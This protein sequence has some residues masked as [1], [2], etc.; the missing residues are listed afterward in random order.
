LALVGQAMLVAAGGLVLI[1]IAISLPRV[2]RVRR[3][4]S[5]LSGSLA[6]HRRELEVLLEEGARLQEEA[7]RSSGA[8]R[9]LL[10]RLRHPLVGALW[11]SYR[12][13]RRRARLALR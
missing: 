1:G 8:L 5:A 2:L 12:T 7:G 6:A 11:T 10:L 13:R 3:R 9:R 4:A